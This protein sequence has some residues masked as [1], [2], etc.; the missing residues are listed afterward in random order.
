MADNGDSL[1][2][3]IVGFFG[4]GDETSPREREMV[5]SPA[6]VKPTFTQ[7]EGEDRTAF[8]IRKRLKMREW[9]A[10]IRQ[11][12]S[13]PEDFMVPAAEAE[14]TEDTSRYNR[15]QQIDQALEDAGA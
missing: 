13:F 14:G 9:E 15:Q 6:P 7:Q 1:Y 2:D 10:L 12:E 11:R 4:G 5:M 3:T 8:N